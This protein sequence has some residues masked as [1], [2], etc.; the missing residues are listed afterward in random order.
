M[1]DAAIYTP[2]FVGGASLTALS[3]LGR[4]DS[5]PVLTVIEAVLALLFGYQAMQA[6]RDLGSQPIRTEGVVGRK[7]TKMDFIVTRSHYV[8][9]GRRIFRLPVEDWYILQEDDR[10]AVVHYPH[11]GTVVKVE[12]A[13]DSSNP[14]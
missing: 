9:L 14:A 7:W 8:A 2:L 6:L 4:V 10:I 11:S 1:R 5:G 13:S 12:P 3:I